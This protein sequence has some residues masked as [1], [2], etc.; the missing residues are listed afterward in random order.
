MEQDKLVEIPPCNWIELRDIFL[1]NWP[2]NHV[3]WHT[4]NN[5]VN[6]NRIRPYIKNLNIYSLND[7][8]KSDGTYVVVVSVLNKQKINTHLL[9]L[10]VRLLF[11]LFVHRTDINCTFTR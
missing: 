9:I 8:W 4:I 11:V 3:A 2:E 7:S 10:C 1:L 5:Y 6:W